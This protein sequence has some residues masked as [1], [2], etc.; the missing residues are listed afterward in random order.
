[1]PSPE[2]VGGLG[3]DVLR[4]SFEVLRLGFEVLGLGYEV[5]PV[6][7]LAQGSPLV[8]LPKGSLRGQAQGPLRGRRI[9]KL[10]SRQSP[11]HIFLYQAPDPVA[12][13]FDTRALEQ[14]HPQNTIRGMI[15]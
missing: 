7:A 8:G 14:D 2:G 5:F 1:M 4:L 6:S 11:K 12:A 15:A 13:I 3:F 9:I 10:I